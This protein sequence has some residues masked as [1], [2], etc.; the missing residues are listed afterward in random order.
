MNI[1]LS[2]ILTYLNGTLFIDYRYQFCKFVV[3]H[4]LEFEDYTL[5]EV[6]EESGLTEEEILSFI[7]LL[8]FHDYAS[9]KK[10]LTQ[11]HYVRLDQIRARML[12]AN[13][14]D[15]IASMEKSGS[16]EE[17][18]EYISTICEAI[19]KARKVVLFGALYP[20]SIAIELQTDLITFG[21][22]VIQYHTFDKDLELD[23]H[24]VTIFITATGR[25]M[26]HFVK[27]KK[28]LAIDKTTSLLITQNKVYTTPEHR[29]SDY[30]IH[31]PGKFDGINFNYE[32]MT[33]CDLLRVHYYSQYYL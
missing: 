2:R 1:L 23:E 5:E 16:D 27:L 7:A 30:V 8:G 14:D 28:E 26:E 3:A 10:T 17:L 32:I 20:V 24:D 29:I 33:I 4:Y 9:F 6:I 21:K 13:S 18:K 12:D 25:S 22:P 11:N 19:Y 15:I 31:I